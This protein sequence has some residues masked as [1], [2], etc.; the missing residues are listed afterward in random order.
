MKAYYGSQVSENMTVT[1]EGFLI[2]LNVPIARTGWYQ[3][4]RSELGLNGDP[5]EIVKVYRSEDEVFS[6]KAMASF[7]GKLVTDNHPPDLLTP[8]NAQRYSKGAVQNVRRDKKETDLLLADLFIHDKRLIKEV[9]DGKREVSCGYDC[10]YI[11]NEDGTYSQTC[12]C[13]NHVAVVDSGRAGDRV[14]IKDSNK[15]KEGAKKMKIKFPKNS[16][17]TRTL[18][19]MGLQQLAQDAEP[20]EIADVVDGIAEENRAKNESKE[21]QEEK[22]PPVEAKDGDGKIE[23]LTQQVAQ[24]TQL[25]KQLTAQKE[26]APEESIDEMIEEL[27]KNDKSTGDE[28]ESVTIPVDEMDEE[29]PGGVVQEES[30]KPKNP[31]PNADTAA[32]IKALKAIKPVIANISDPEEKKKACDSLKVEFNKLNTTK[33]KA[34]DN[35]Y[36]QIITAQNIN[37]KKSVK[38]A[39]QKQQEA[40]KIGEDLK[41]KFNPHYKGDK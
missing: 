27:S 23:E 18:V 31:I 1:P 36:E 35:N 2:C 37:A 3:Y 40:K 22:K 39:D 28:E 4:L 11:D 16:P 29:I 9:K 15:N 25:V 5:N 41:K 17:V 33:K 7:E 30:E 10:I 13:G 34:K 19:A 20:D 6:S 21:V 32:M 26:K 14:A 24:L 8:D 12:I 38:T